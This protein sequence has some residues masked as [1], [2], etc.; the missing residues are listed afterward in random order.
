MTPSTTAE[1]ERSPTAEELAA[2]M[3][4]LRSQYCHSD[5]DD[6]AAHYYRRI[7]QLVSASSV[8][9]VNWHQNGSFTFRYPSP[10]APKTSHCIATVSA[11]IWSRTISQLRSL[12]HVLDAPDGSDIPPALV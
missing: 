6:T 4:Y 2:I 1:T 5:T 3:E 7:Q 8:S 12:E 10:Y 11:E 9:I